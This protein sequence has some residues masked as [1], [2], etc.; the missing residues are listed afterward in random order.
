MS[1]PILTA[2][3][4]LGR[5]GWGIHVKNIRERNDFKIVD[6]ADPDPKRRE[7]AAQE[8]NC[9]THENID[10]LLKNTNAELVVVAT[11]SSLHE[12]DTLKVFKAKK[13]CLVEKPMAMSYKGGL[14]MIQAAKKAKRKLF[15]H[16]N[17][18]FNN[19]FF[20]FRE[21]IDS[22]IIGNVFS[23][24]AYW[25]SF[26]RRNDWQTL[27]KNGGGQLNNTCP[28]VI[29]NV[30]NMMDAPIVSLVGDLQLIK[31][32]GDAEDHVHFFMKAKNG[33]TADIIVSTA[34]AIP[35]PKWVFFGSCGGLSSDGKTT[36]LRYYDPNAVPKLKVIDGA[37]ANRKYGNDDVLPWKEETRPTAP[38]NNYGSFYDSVANTLIHGKP[39]AVTPE[40]GADVLRITEW[41]RK[42]TKFPSAIPK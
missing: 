6:V 27:R 7:E 31:D 29:D 26:K 18:R 19:E 23:I 11:P 1:N 16:H 21:I 33:R 17:Y 13:H 38:I 15:V 40:Q 20:H 24:R 41:I 10:Q 3:V 9:G 5:A 42:G 37:A 25:Q 36:T 12:I 30:L 35:G 32:A 28:H 22:G 34:A 8:F 39:M 14:R 4:G 2:V